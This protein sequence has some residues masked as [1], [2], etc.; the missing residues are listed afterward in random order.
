MAPEQA[1]ASRDADERS[2]IYS[3]G[4]ILYE[5]L[6]GEPPYGR[7]TYPVVLGRLMTQDP[8]DIGDLVPGLGE[9]MVDVVRRA[10]A[11]DPA[12]R[13][14]TAA[15]M[16]AVLEAS[17]DL[18]APRPL[19]TTRRR[20]GREAAPALAGEPAAT[21][22]AAES[23]RVVR[24]GPPLALLGAGLG[25]GLLGAIAWAALSGPSS[26]VQPQALMP[27]PTQAPPLPAAAL[28]P[29]LP[30]PPPAAS[31]PLAPAQAAPT[32]RRLR[33]AVTPED[34]RARVVV[35]LRSGVELASGGSPSLFTLA[36]GDEALRVMVR[37]PGFRQA[38][39]DLAP[40]DEE[41]EIA[42]VRIQSARKNHGPTID[43]RNPLR[44]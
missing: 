44:R 23:M 29:V 20:P 11:R 1:Q 24:R 39:R 18:T 36:E 9:G 22:F 14:P 42:L 13:F 15:A 21:P 2:D 26:P 6:S 19:P 33:V 3:V 10:M 35:V 43:D 27:T 25:V 40:S 30:A 17:V 41:V 16:R 8:V 12:D 37:A 31:P 32:P 5:C 4:A 34:A 28:P 38:A 7:D